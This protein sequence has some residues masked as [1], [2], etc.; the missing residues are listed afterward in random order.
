VSASF[1][2]SRS[3]ARPSVS[4]RYSLSQT[5]EAIHIQ[6]YALSSGMHLIWYVTLEIHL[7]CM[8]VSN[9]QIDSDPLLTRLNVPW[10]GWC[11]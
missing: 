4:C 11:A 2:D 7:Q 5:A 8:G 9:L 6:V 10:L 3:L 1:P